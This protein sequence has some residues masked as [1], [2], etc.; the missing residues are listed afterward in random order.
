V[1]APIFDYSPLYLHGL[2]M[3]G[4]VSITSF[5]DSPSKASRP[6]DASREGFVP[7]HGGAVI[8]IESSESAKKRN[9]KIYSEIVGVEVNSSALSS[10]APMVESYL[11]GLKRLFESSKVK[12]SEIDFISAHATSTPQGDVV[13]ISAIKEFFKDHAS[14]LKINAPKSILG[15]T[16]SSSAIVE[17]VLAVLQMNNSKVHR[18][19]NIDELDPAI[20]LD[21]CRNSNQEIKINYLLKNAFGFGGLNSFIILKNTQESK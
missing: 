17:L 10:A 8:L 19:I 1:V 5:N 20:D 9:A 7:A 12:P 13:E 3:M 21:V 16:T 11:S 18:S 2:D 14:K 4:A 15:H 6:F